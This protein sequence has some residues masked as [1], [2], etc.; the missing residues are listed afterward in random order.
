[1][2]PEPVRRSGGVLAGVTAAAGPVSDRRAVARGSRLLQTG[3]AGLCVSLILPQFLPGVSSSYL[4]AVAIACVAALLVANT[5]DP[6]ERSTSLNLFVWALLCRVLAVTACYA[7]GVREGGPFLGPDSTTYFTRG[8][9]LAASAFHLGMHPM[10]A[11]GS[12]DVSHYYLFAA[13][14]R[15]LHADLFGLQVMNGCLIA[16]AA[17]LVYGIARTILPSSALVLGLAVALHPSLVAISSIDL[18]K[19]PSIILATV[20]LVW[21]I[22]RLTLERKVHALA[23]YFAV[24][25]VAAVYLRTGRFYSFAYLELAF[26]VTVAIMALLRT[27][28]FQRTA[29]AV[30]VVGIFL[31]GEVVPARAA[32]PP[33]P[34][35]VASAVSYVLDTP[36]MSRYAAGFFDRLRLPSKGGGIAGDHD[37]VMVPVHV[38]PKSGR[39]A[40]VGSVVSVLANLFRR[41]YGPFVWI[42]PDDWHFRVLQAGD[43][44]LFPGMLVWYGLLPVIAVGLGATAW[45]I[46][47]RSEKRFGV[48]FLWLF[49]AVYFAQYL[50]INLSYRQRDVMLPVLLIF[51]AVGAPYL[52]R[53]AWWRT[54]YTGYWIALIL[55]ASV[56]ILA[57][58]FMSA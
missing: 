9:E 34:V 33:S 19:D 39:F 42:L 13:T 49:A 27:T 40:I 21:V 1:M 41:L 46:L 55:I 11:Y 8:G 18:L 16:L 28:V 29:G 31:I 36:A 26:V 37:P 57:R 6:A 47:K 25:V 20:L 24:G 38:G 12:Y 2:L 7:L 48:V 14:V 23:A 4:S 3:V 44:L 22:V 56:H 54:W 15:Y 35:M 43:F 52:A 58:T 50:M 30:L 51:A 10:L 17:P 53:F 45:R 5:E 32:W